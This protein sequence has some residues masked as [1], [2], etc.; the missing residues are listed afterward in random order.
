M[1]KILVANR[2]EIA[3]NAI[4][5]IRE[6]GLTPVAVYSEADENALH[7][8]YAEKV[9]RL[10][11]ERPTHNYASIDRLLEAAEQVGADAIYPGY[12]FLSESPELAIAC[13]DRNLTYVGPTPEALRLCRN[14][15]ALL[16]KASGLGMNVP[17]HSKPIKNEEDLVSGAQKIGYPI[18]I[19]PV[20]GIGARFM[21]KA[22]R[23]EDLLD[24]FRRLGRE[25]E[26]QG[27]RAPF[28]LEEYVRKA[29]H[30]EITVLADQTGQVI[31][32][33]ERE[34]VI[35]RRFQKLI[36]ET[37]SSQVPPEVLRE[38]SEAALELVRAIEF[39]GCCSVEFLVDSRN[40]WYFMEINPRIQVE[41]ALTEL[42]YG[43]EVIKEQFRIAAGEKLRLEAMGAHPRL[44]AIECRINAEDPMNDFRPSAGVISEYYLPGG[45]GY[46]VLSSVQK[47]H[48]VDIYYDPMI[49]KLNCFAGTRDEALSKLRF[50]LDAIRLK[51]IHTNIPF[52]RRVVA[53]K[54]FVE[55]RLKLDFKYKD[56]L[57]GNDRNRKHLEVAAIVA[58]MDQ[59]IIG[60]QRTPSYKRRQREINVWNMS[61]RVDLINRRSL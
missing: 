50:A 32:L 2:G 31:H 12:G 52:L 39:T 60:H 8:R 9:V 53:A 47:G 15:L 16:E 27:P 55:G 17:K 46:S 37:P 56:F 41:Y 11:G 13:R 24:Y 36:S 22:Y 58:A 38:L 5:C 3:L 61:G 45:F 59:E 54:D 40:R 20:L 33:G 57:P 18:L 51:G 44:H 10:P 23:K 4:R 26:I 43:V 49:L 21:A 30:V 35:Q 28:Y 19:K 25:Q 7:I 34:S 6:M 48:R 1:K 42:R 29:A 14:K